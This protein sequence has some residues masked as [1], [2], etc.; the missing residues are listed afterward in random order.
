MK[1]VNARLER[2]I[3]DLLEGACRKH[4]GDALNETFYEDAND[5][6]YE[7]YQ[8]ME[9]VLDEIYDIMKEQIDD[10]YTNIYNVIINKP[11]IDD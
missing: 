4:M 9:G 11:S 6:L 8:K 3:K 1:T 7:D 10:V 2:S 5:R